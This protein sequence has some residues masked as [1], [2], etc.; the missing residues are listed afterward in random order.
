MRCVRGSNALNFRHIESTCE[1]LHLL[2]TH[3][4][5]P[6]NLRKTEDRNPFEIHFVVHV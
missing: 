4:P 2:V 3:I 1:P 5:P 6:H